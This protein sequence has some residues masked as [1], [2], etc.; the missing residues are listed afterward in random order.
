MHYALCR[1]YR[2][3]QVLSRCAYSFH[4]VSHP[5]CL[6]LPRSLRPGPTQMS[7]DHF[8][9][10]EPQHFLFFSCSTVSSLSI[11][12]ELQSNFLEPCGLPTDLR[13]LKS[14]VGPHSPVSQNLMHVLLRGRTQRVQRSGCPR[15]PDYQSVTG[16]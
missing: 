11:K 4:T 3:A 9:G 16:C 7:Q 1:T 15:L 5:S 8:P 14:V 6:L 13:S 10:S 2:G 12:Y